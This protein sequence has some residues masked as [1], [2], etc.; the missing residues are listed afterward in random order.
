[1]QKNFQ[2]RIVKT[3][4]GSH[5]LE[6][7]GMDEHYHSTFGAVQESR[8]VFIQHGLLALSGKNAVVNI[9]EIGFGTGLNALLTLLEAEKAKQQVVYHA[10]EPFPL[11]REEYELLNYPA[12]MKKEGLQQTFINFHESEW[13]NDI[14]ISPGFTLRKKSSGLGEANLPANFF[15]LVYFDAFGPDTQPEL[16][17]QPMF[18]KL[19]LAMTAGGILTTYCAKGSVRRAMKASGLAVEKLPGPPGKREMTRAVKR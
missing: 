6:L 11:Q 4:D 14:E 1:M 18:E 8:H 16:W 3:D 17:T 10:L 12:L 13:D 19:F 2:R 7:V 9:L 15:H 5:T